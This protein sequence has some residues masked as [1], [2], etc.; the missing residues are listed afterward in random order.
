MTLSVELGLSVVAHGSV[1][2]HCG[3]Y[4]SWHPSQVRL[5][6]NQ[7]WVWNIR[8]VKEGVKSSGQQYKREGKNILRGKIII[9]DTTHL[10]WYLTK[11]EWLSSSGA[12]CFV[13]GTKQINEQ[14]NISKQISTV[15]PVLSGPHIKRTPST[16]WTAAQVPFFSFQIYCK[17]YPYS[18]DTSIKRTRTP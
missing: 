7:L 18:T 15:K 8:K 6:W 5:H 3:G 17:K 1:R 14:I 13:T 9:Q 2:A 10:C 12:D 11:P 16:K 4:H